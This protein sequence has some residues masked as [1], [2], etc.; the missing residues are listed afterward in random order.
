MNDSI[1][2]NLKTLA[3]NY[4]IQTS[5]YDVTKRRR[6]ASSEGLLKLLHALGASVQKERDVPD[7][8]RAS[9][10]ELWQQPLE[11]VAVAWD[12]VFRRLSIRLPTTWL[13][14]S[15]EIS[16][17]LESGEEYR[18]SVNARDLSSIAE[19]HIEGSAYY[20]KELTVP[21][22]VLQ[23]LPLGYHHVI[24]ERGDAQYRMLLVSAP[25]KAYGPRDQSVS[26]E[27]G[28][29]LPLY[30]LQSSR[31]WGIG[32]FTDLRNLT[33]WVQQQ[34][35]SIVATLPLLATFV[36]PI[37]E[38]SP[39]APISRLFWNEWYTDISQVPETQGYPE[40]TTYL[41]SEA[42]QR[43]RARLA[44]SS[45]VDYRKILKL[46]RPALA[47][48]SKKFFKQ[49]SSRRDVFQR[50]LSSHPALYEYAR[51]RATVDKQQTPWQK[52][53]DSLRKGTLTEDDY[54]RET[55]YYHL[56]TQW[57]AGEQL[58]ALSEHSRQ[59]G[60]GLYLDLPL[61]VH[62]G[63]YDVW[64]E[65]SAFVLD[66][67]GG[68]PADS[69][70]PKGQD[71]GF[72][73]LHPRG[74]RQEGYRY[75]IAYLRHHMEQAGVLRIDHVMGLHRLY[76][77]PKGLEVQQGAYVRYRPEELYGIM[78]LESHRHHTILVGENLGT[79]PRHINRSLTQHRLHRLYVVQYELNPQNQSPLPPIP[80]DA[81]ASLNTHDMPPFAGYWEGLDI[82]ECMTLGLLDSSQAKDEK[83]RRRA[84]R[85]SLTH[86][87]RD[88]RLLS[89]DNP[90]TGELLKGCL[91]F[92][93]RSNAPFAL[94]N[95]EDLWLETQPQNIPASHERRP[96]W[97]KK[98]RL[99]LEE[100]QEMTEV[101]RL[102]KEFHAARA[103][104]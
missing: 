58:H 34:G 104:H 46:K 75:V 44:S 76:M 16:V 49:P 32:D 92:I 10:T 72:A 13:G 11:P 101:L 53:P 12:G 93:G 50:Y 56:Y 81:V 43:E 52:W 55:Y 33:D 30:A 94:V 54:D 98:A 62:T 77:I 100:I 80:R 25:V 41:E 47:L 79:V 74:I 14:Q 17:Q 18:W 96:N 71:W 28:I 8:L 64:R 7:A 2:P 61:G 37:F 21:A 66:A 103:S 99:S 88:K 26:K 60:Q 83:K 63:G 9:Q 27:W 68:A 69:V 82:D 15:L 35:G 87:L 22:S 6:Q 51:F 70:F 4:D 78:N 36:D 97:T 38:P 24:L 40:Y 86:F 67:V 31:S 89:T 73:P 65:R 42:T 39:Y 1:R 95:L 59:K 48:L 45:Y 91:E 102:L 19:T 5:Y 20:L 90:S 3:H 57:I 85:S 23:K 84:S 29:F